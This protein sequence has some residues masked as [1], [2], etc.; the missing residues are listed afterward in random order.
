MLLEI[1]GKTIIS[2]N[3][4]KK[5]PAFLKTSFFVD[6]VDAKMVSLELKDGGVLVVV[7]DDTVIAGVVLYVGLAYSGVSKHGAVKNTKSSKAI[8]LKNIRASL[9]NICL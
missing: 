9:L 6:I 7:V 2:L 4:R 8:S 1:T 3:L 5:N